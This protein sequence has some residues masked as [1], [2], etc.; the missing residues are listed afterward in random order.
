MCKR[1]VNGWVRILSLC[2]LPRRE[3]HQL[4]FDVS[5]IFQEYGIMHFLYAGSLLGAYRNHGVMAWDSDVDLILPK[6]AK[7]QL[8]SL[9]DVLRERGFVLWNSN[10]SWC[11][12][13]FRVGDEARTDGVHGV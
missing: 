10:V 9:S 2:F 11:W 12:K 8:L 5:R 6:V 1:S 7:H 4:L 13:I 3:L